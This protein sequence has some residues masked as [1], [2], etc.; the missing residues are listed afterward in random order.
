MLSPPL[1]FVIVDVKTLSNHPLSSIL[2]SPDD[3]GCC[4]LLSSLFCNSDR[5]FS[6]LLAGLWVLERVSGALDHVDADRQMANDIMP[7]CP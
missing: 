2:R 1:I 4:S 5:E 6:L 7:T 3:L